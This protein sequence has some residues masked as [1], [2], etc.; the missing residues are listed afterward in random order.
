MSSSVV[1]VMRLR[2]VGTTK[3]CFV[4]LI[5][6]LTDLNFTLYFDCV[7][8]TIIESMTILL[9]FA[10]TSCMQST[11]WNV[12]FPFFYVQTHSGV[13]DSW[14]LWNVLSNN[15]VNEIQW[16]KGDNRWQP[17]VICWKNAWKVW[18]HV[19]ICQEVCKVLLQRQF[20]MLSSIGF[21]LGSIL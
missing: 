1:L 15:I 3:L 13:A 6:P 20:W 11:Y 21:D 9:W 2:Y 18:W 7:A 14:H 5:L 10:V 16:P 8:E 17:V 19:T 4:N 12:G